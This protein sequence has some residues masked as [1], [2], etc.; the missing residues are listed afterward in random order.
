[1]SAAC[2]EPLVTAS[3]I[4]DLSSESSLPAS[5]ACQVVELSVDSSTGE[6]PAPA[7]TSAATVAMPSGLISTP[8]DPV[9]CAATSA[10]PDTAGADPE[11]AGSGSCHLAPIPKARSAAVSCCG[12]RVRDMFAN[13]VPQPSAKSEASV[14]VLDAAG[15]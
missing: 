8:P 6:C 13:A 5:G 12:V 2:A 7:A 10:S 1:M 9:A 11:K 15:W 4:S 3:R 14:A